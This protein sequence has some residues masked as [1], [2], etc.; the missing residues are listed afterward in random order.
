MPGRC[1]FLSASVQRNWGCI[2]YPN[3]SIHRYLDIKPATERKIRITDIS[4]PH[5]SY[6]QTTNKIR[7]PVFLFGSSMQCK[8]HRYTLEKNA[9][10]RMKSPFPFFP[11]P[12]TRGFF[13]RAT[14][15]RVSVP[16][17]KIT[18]LFSLTLWFTFPFHKTGAASS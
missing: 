5:R 17:C 14:V 13:F 7:P 18:A 10:L 4:C 16:V 15:K 1:W 11:A 6:Q 9:P 12:T 8:T 3:T 2:F